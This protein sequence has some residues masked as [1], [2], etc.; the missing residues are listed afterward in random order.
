[1]YRNE[2]RNSSIETRTLINLFFFIINSSIIF[3]YNPL[4]IIS[5]VYFLTLLLTVNIV[6]FKLNVFKLILSYNVFSLAM[7]ILLLLQLSSAPEYYGLTPGRGIGTD[8]VFFYSQSSNHYPENFLLHSDAYKEKHSYS[9]ILIFFS[10]PLRYIYSLLPIDFLFINV[11]IMSLIPVMTS[12]VAWSI[13]KN[14]KVKKWAYI[15]SI[16]CPLYVMNGLIMVRDG[17]TASLLIASV[18]FLLN[19]RYYKMVAIVVLQFIIRIA[20]G[21]ELL[22]VLG[23]FFFAVTRSK[24]SD[25]GSLKK[26]SKVMILL[27]PLLMMIGFYVFNNYISLKLGGNIFFREEFVTG[28]LAKSEDSMLYSI[29]Q[30][31]FYARIPISTIFFVLAPFIN[32]NFFVAGY[33]L[34]R[35]ILGAIFGFLN[36]FYLRY[37]VNAIIASYKQNNLWIKMILVTFVLMLMIISQLSMQ[38]RHKTM[39][40]P[41]YYILVSYGIC[42]STNTSKLIGIIAS[43]MLLLANVF[44]MF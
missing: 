36:I 35:T 28:F 39:F 5:M 25:I 12:D 38:I 7:L 24:S 40:M 2:I 37:F 22:M 26:V 15:L 31:P 34:P 30:L 8:D 14:L 13:T 3:L 42:Y 10:L 32:L 1:M 21:L 43:V 33:F 18:Y 27:L 11:M 29:M 20:S 17:W 6:F 16:I 44:V 19:K 41:L 4:S 9:N 23:F